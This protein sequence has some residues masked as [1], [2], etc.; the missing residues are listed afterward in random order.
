M[1]KYFRLLGI[2]LILSLFTINVIA[3]DKSPEKSKITKGNSAEALVAGM[4]DEQARR[5]LIVELKKEAGQKSTI[6]SAGSIAGFIENIKNK[7]TRIQQR[8]EFLRS[9][10]KTNIQQMSGL[11]A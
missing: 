11:F 2:I 9:G 3:S 7:V 4:S 5:L 10:G 8:I 1:K 6:D